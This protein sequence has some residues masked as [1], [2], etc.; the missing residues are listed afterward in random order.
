MLLSCHILVSIW[1]LKCVAVVN[2]T[3]KGKKKQTVA[4]T[5]CPI[6]KK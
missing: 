1:H 6:V 4:I 3:Y 2:G 5:V